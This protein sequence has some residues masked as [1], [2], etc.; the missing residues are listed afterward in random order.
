MPS[1]GSTKSRA[2]ASRAR[3]RSL[4]SCLPFLLVARPAFAQPKTAE[5]GSAPTAKTDAKAEESPPTPAEA[6]P[7]PSPAA[8]EY[9]PWPAKAVLLPFEA[10][11]LSQDEVAAFTALFVQ[12]YQDSSGGR[13]MPPQETERALQAL[14]TPAA[15]LSASGAEQYL[16]GTIVHLD[17]RF[18]ISISAY[19]PK[20][21]RLEQQKMTA[22]GVDDFEPIAGRLAKALSKSRSAHDVRSLDDVTAREGQ[23]RQRVAS[24]R[25][26]GLR[27]G[28]AIPISKTAIVP[29]VVA[30]LDVRFES[31]Q[32]AVGFS[33]GLLLPAGDVDGETGYGGLTSDVNVLY[34]LTRESLSPYVAGGLNMRIIGSNESGGANLA[35]FVGLG[36]AL[37]REAKASAYLELRV[38]Q[39]VTP[40]RF[41]IDADPTVPGSVD[42]SRAEYPFEPSLN[43][44]IAF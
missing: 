25:M 31:E 16:S 11:N 13:V 24:E 22:T 41:K 39:N 18:V 12:A 33:I 30:A 23:A 10:T 26:A 9:K 42:T 19:D 34:Y 40:I 15:V 35:P 5:A 28:V 21:N 6:A 3:A 37:G 27:G 14:S 2:G 43:A 38:A 36:L 7:N 17:S 20:G 44:A 4:L 8:S 1:L 32:H 29:L